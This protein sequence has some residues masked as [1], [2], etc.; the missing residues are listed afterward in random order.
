[1]KILNAR[2]VDIH[3]N[4]FFLLMLLMY[5]SVGL[6]SEMAF[7][8][9]TVALHELAHIVVAGE[10]G[11]KVKKIEFLPFGGMIEFDEAFYR[12]PRSEILISLA[13]PI[14]NLVF[15]GFVFVL[16]Q[17]GILPAGFGR[18]VFELN[19]AMGLFNLLPAI[20]L[21]GGRAARA[22]LA[23]SIGVAQA[24]QIA[25]NIGRAV[26]FVM[27]AAGV[28]LFF[29]GE[30]N[31][32]LPSLGGFLIFAASKEWEKV[33]YMRVQDSIRKKERLMKERCMPAEV[34]AAHEQTLLV[35]VARRFSPGKISIVMVLSDGLDILG[36][37]TE[38][39]VFEGMRRYGPSV[40]IRR[41][42]R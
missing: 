41:M 39:K 38:A 25:A 42:V 5:G 15:A 20:P 40:P 32:F 13:G 10:L 4:P 34:I 37:V 18:F 11:W 22:A 19:L 36:F 12:S 26:G 28:Y 24:T 14:H 9:W 33:L 3:I 6:L 27:L 16:L 1:M 2:G 30:G 17:K 29:K 21:D 8:L 31:I 35:E 23:S 7:A